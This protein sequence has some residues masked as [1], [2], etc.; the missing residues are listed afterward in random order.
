[1]PGASAPALQQKC[2]FHSIWM[3]RIHESIQF[4]G[5]FLRQAWTGQ[6]P[7]HLL[8][9]MLRLS[10]TL[11]KRQRT[12][13]E[14][15]RCALRLRSV[16]QR[17]GQQLRAQPLPLRLDFSKPPKRLETQHIDFKR[18]HV[19]WLASAAQQ[20]SVV[21]VTLPGWD[22]SLGYRSVVTRMRV[23]P[24]LTVELLQALAGNQRHPLRQLHGIPADCIGRGL[25]QVDLSALA[26]TH[27][28]LV[29]DAPGQAIC[30]AAL[31][32]TLQSLE[33]SEE[34]P[35]G[36]LP[37]VQDMWSLPCLTCLHVKSSIINVPSS[38]GTSWHKTH[39]RLTAKGEILVNYNSSAEGAVGLF[40]AASTV[41]LEA[42]SITFYSL[43]GGGRS[44]GNLLAC[45]ARTRLV[46]QSW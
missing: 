42:D 40:G 23:S 19:H 24:S 2:A 27:L 36:Y 22:M 28:G 8:L 14:E 45:Y 10:W 25:R 6:M 46:G 5:W 15:V 12:P 17:I 38:L 1:M 16:C 21:A 35:A 34:C 32:R 3:E 11:D 33:C 39:V 18:E 41:R 7:D 20:D 26:L 37:E 29:L 44:S 31:P 30:A 4:V 9:G 13:A 43:H